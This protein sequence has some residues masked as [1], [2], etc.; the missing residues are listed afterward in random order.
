MN[1]KEIRE[2]AFMKATFTFLAVSILWRGLEILF[3]GCPKESNE[4]TII[5][6]VMWYYIIKS[7]FLKYGVWPKKRKE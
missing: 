5:G 7:E 6:L 2:Y 3:Y 4:D 1:D